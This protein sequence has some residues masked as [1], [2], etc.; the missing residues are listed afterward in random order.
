M[1][2]QA[3]F[4]DYHQPIFHALDEEPDEVSDVR[5]DFD[6]KGPRWRN[7]QEAESEDTNSGR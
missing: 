5:A 2:Q 6:V 4:H 1:V 7:L 3:S